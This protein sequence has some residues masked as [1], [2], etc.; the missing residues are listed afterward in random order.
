M[1]VEELTR[2]VGLKDI[3]VEGIV[4]ESAEEVHLAVRPANGLPLCRKCGDPCLL[5]HSTRARVVRRRAGRPA[6]STRSTR[7]LDKGPA[8]NQ[9]PCLWPRSR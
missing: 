6:R 1:R 7:G 2:V 5:V 9:N 3:V 8:P 4:S